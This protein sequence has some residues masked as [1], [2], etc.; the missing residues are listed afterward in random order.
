MTADPKDDFYRLTSALRGQSPQPDPAAKR[1]AMMQAMKN[2]DEL[3]KETD[4]EMRPTQDRPEKKAGF[5]RGVRD[6]FYNLTSKQAL[7][8]TTSVAAICIGMFVI[9]PLQDVG[10][11][12]PLGEVQAPAQEAVSSPEQAMTQPAEAQE[13]AEP[14][15]PAQLQPPVSEEAAASVEVPQVEPPAAPIATADQSVQSGGAPNMADAAA[16]RQSA[17][18][19]SRAET[20]ATANGSLL[21]V[22]P[23]AAFESMASA[24]MAFEP[25]IGNAIILPEQ[26]TET[27]ANADSNPVKVT[28]EEPVSTFSADV[29]TA[30]YAVVRDSLMSGYLPPAEAVRVEEMINYFPYSYPAPDAQAGAPFNASVAVM[31]TPWNADTQLVRIGLQGQMPAVDDRP[32]LNLVFLIDTSGSMQDPDK[33]PLLKQSLRMMLGQLRPEDQV[34]IV[35]YAGSAG[36]VL[37]PTAASDSAKILS[38]LD[39]LD[40]GGSTNGAEG[41]E[42][43]YRAADSM[44]EDGEVSRILLATDGDFNVGISDP[45]GLEGYIARKRDAGTYLSVL[46]FGRG[47]LDD[48]T[49]QAIAQNGNGQA[50]Y[51]DTLQEAQKVLV[52]QLSG[53]LFPIAGD[54]K[55]QV[56]WNPAEVAEYRLIGYETRA[57]RR[58]DFNND[59]V[60]AGELGAGHAVTAIYEVTPLDSPALLNDSLRYQSDEAVGDA[61]GEL[62]FLRMRYKSPGESESQLIET[63]ILAQQGEPDEDARFAAAIAGFGQLLTGA[64]Y[65]GEWGWDDAIALAQSGRGDDPFGYRN[66][67][68]SLMRLAE[69]LEASDAGSTVPQPGTRDFIE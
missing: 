22:A 23:N 20:E 36:Q 9:L 51:I 4:D 41:L 11:Q 27:F 62:G 10:Y 68:I 63:P 53:A 34:A 66:E 12:A 32:P 35:T 25:P 57:L 60:D 48:A 3:S 8:A 28:T 7:A 56:E 50:A 55:L 45:E 61:D 18:A 19:R 33:L 42:L 40:A 67:A 43:A 31:Q 13:Q 59:K 52:D 44:A 47:N 38:A 69:S 17:P 64:S 54:V 21:G 14:Q 58:E 65:L 29:D 49:M 37:E 2:F 6:M 15:Q 1:A 26:N 24:D 30:S 39:R 46:G 5:L 16:S